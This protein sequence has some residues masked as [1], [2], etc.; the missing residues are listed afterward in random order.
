MRKFVTMDDKKAQDWGRAAGDISDQTRIEIVEDNMDPA[1]LKAMER[2]K[3]LQ[4]TL[5]KLDAG[6]W[7][8]R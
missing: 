3:E 2:Y 4:V 6:T 1:A 7:S 5:G 8:V